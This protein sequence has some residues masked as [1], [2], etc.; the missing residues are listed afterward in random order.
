MSEKL[1]EQ[2]TVKVSESVSNTFTRLANVEGVSPS[3]L[4]RN[5]IDVYI[6]KKHEDFIL[7]SKA[8]AIQVNPVN[9]ENR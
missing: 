6:Q 5:L 4:L 3:D 9:K 2:I 8:F 7:L 1:S